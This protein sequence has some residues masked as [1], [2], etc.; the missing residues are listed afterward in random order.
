MLFSSK[1]VW[2]IK[3]LNFMYTDSKFVEIDSKNVPKKQR[4]KVQNPKNSKIILLIA[5]NFFPEHFFE[6]INLCLHP[7]EI[8]KKY[9]ISAPFCTV[10]F[11]VLKAAC[12]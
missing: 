10:P 8:P 1:F 12:S 6:P 2:G 3:K 11:R 7:F 4:K 9:K 5:Y